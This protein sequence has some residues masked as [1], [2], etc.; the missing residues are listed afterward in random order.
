MHATEVV[1]RMV[2]RNH[3]AVVLEFLREGIRQPCEAP[4]AHSQIQVLPLYIT[5]RDVLPIR[6][7]AQDACANAN[8]LCGAIAGIGAVCGCAIQL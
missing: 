5:G 6:I 2:D 4:D 3:V 1:V 7:P 8:A